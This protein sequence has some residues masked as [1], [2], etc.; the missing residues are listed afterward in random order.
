MSLL[1]GID[2]G[3]TFTDFVCFDRSSNDIKAWKNLSTPENPFDGVLT[4]LKEIPNLGDVDKARLGTTIA[5]NAILQRK[6]ADTAYITTKGFK[7]IPFIQRGNR[8]A[9]YDVTWIKSKP[10]VKRQNCFEIEDIP[11]YVVASVTS[12][13][14][15]TFLIAKKW[16]QTSCSSGIVG[17]VSPEMI[18]AT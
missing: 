5:T 8:K 1:I 18:Y 3:G 14:K 2:I 9:H 12:H 7:D 13:D 15:A 10:L 17:Q 6:G 4:G 16:H 11:I